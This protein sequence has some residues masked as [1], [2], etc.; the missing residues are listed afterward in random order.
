MLLIA[1]VLF[2]MGGTLLDYRGPGGW[3]ATLASAFRAVYDAV[4]AAGY[5]G[6]W[7]P[8]RERLWALEERLWTEAL[9][10]Q[11]S[12]TVEGE[13]VELLRELGLPRNPGLVAR[14]ARA[15]GQALQSACEV[16]PDSAETLAALK[17]M[18]LK[19]GLISNTVLPGEAHVE[20]LARFGLL[21]YF[22]DLV[23]SSD[24]GLWKPQA[25]IFHL[26]LGRLGLRPGEALFVGD[27]LIDDV[28]GAQGAGLLGVLRV[29]PGEGPDGAAGEAQG[30]RPDARILALAELPALV[31]KLKVGDGSPRGF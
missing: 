26:A 11:A 24:V 12:P 2:D 20:D 14:C 16:F 4:S 13:V 27:R 28:G 23:F 7:E 8:F 17:A 18:G 31:E 10:G 22:D 9:G 19:I 3:E 1:G 25:A 21:G 5:R 6:E 29:A 30:I 15:Y